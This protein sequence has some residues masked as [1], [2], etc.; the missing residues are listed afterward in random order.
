MQS[1]VP[2]IG[3]ICLH[4]QGCHEVQRLTPLRAVL[5]YQDS[6]QD[7]RNVRC[8]CPGGLLSGLI[9]SIAYYANRAR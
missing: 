4:V 7:T 6:K 3:S 1:Y 8:N 9:I 5:A 2:G